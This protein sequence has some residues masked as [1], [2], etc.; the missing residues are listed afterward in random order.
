EDAT[1]DLSN[2]LRSSVM[3][4]LLQNTLPGRPAPNLAHLLL[5]FP[6][7]V[8][9]SEMTIQDPEALGSSRSCL[10]TI[11]D[12]VNVGVP[13]LTSPSQRADEQV[14]NGFPP[15]FERNPVFA[16]QCYRLIYQ[17]SVHDFTCTPTVRYLRTREDFFARHLAALPAKAS[18]P[19]AIAETSG[20]VAVYGDQSRVPATSKALSAFLR[21]RAALLEC[22]ALEL[23]VLRETKQPQRMTRLL[24][25]LFDT[26]NY[27]P[28]RPGQST[29]ESVMGGVPAP[30][31]PLIR[32]LEIF[33]SLDFEWVD[34]IVRQPVD[35]MIYQDANFDGCLDVDEDGCLVYSVPLVVAL[36]NKVKRQTQKLAATM[37]EQQ[38][39]RLKA[40]TRYVL[41]SCM[42]E[43]HRRQIEYAREVSFVAWRHVL[44]IALHECF[45]VLPHGQ[46][47][48]L[49]LDILQALPAYL[50]RANVSA[51]TAMLLAE[52]VLSLSTK[53]REDRHRQLILQSTV[54]DSFAAS[55]PVERIHAI[56]R[57]IVNSAL[58]SGTSERFRGNLYA[59]MT[60][61]IHLVTA[62]AGAT[63]SSTT[64]GSTINKTI[65]L[66]VDDSRRDINSLALSTGRQTIV[67]RTAL[68]SGTL[69][70]VNMFVDRLV[71]LACRDA[72]D[73][74]EVWK[75]VSFTFLDALVQLSRTEKAHRVLNVMAREGFLKNFVH[76]LKSSDADLQTVLKPE[77]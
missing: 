30:A 6:L 56:F 45:D 12:L 4:L 65:S 48:H 5:G 52:V 66:L 31:Q 42:V 46:R 25:L 58:R 68:E 11:L 54:D 75:T 44:D 39:L 34:S 24:Q 26:T 53:L 60:N 32:I 35:L 22:V 3:S 72:A 47:E 43:N 73:G 57:S 62:D 51:A 40:E 49:I 71:P 16:E 27:V 64:P 8:A 17:L 63:E 77:P 33:E 67:K 10:H 28:F 29:L 7:R 14:E 15:L 9:P 36:I 20:G 76:S 74:S 69:S 18:L 59:A 23:H 21:L 13:R 1:T 61:F 55:L 2:A 70:I 50:A 41:E 38:Q 37:S 19:Q